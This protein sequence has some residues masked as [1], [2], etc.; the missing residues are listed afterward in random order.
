MKHWVKNYRSKSKKDTEKQSEQR[1]PYLTSILDIMM[2][3]VDH[4]QLVL[5]KTLKKSKR[6]YLV[7]SPGGYVDQRWKQ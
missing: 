7:K 1:F 5:M 4:H 2:E 3:V 6:I